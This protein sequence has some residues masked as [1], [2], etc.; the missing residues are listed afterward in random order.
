MIRS[1]ICILFLVVVSF[2]Q[3]SSNGDYTKVAKNTEDG[4]IIKL[5][6]HR[7]C[8]VTLYINDIHFIDTTD[9]ACPISQKIQDSSVKKPHRGW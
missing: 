4:G 1:F 3:T 5:Y 7:P 6:V 8:T 9:Y 2:S